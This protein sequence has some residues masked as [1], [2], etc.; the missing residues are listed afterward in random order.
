MESVQLTNFQRHRKLK[1][2]FG[3]TVNVL[4]GANDRGKTA[5]IRALYLAA[6]N[7]PRGVRFVRRGA[8]TAVVSLRADGRKVKRLRGKK[9]NAYYLDGKEF[10]AFGVNGVPPQVERLLNLSPA[11]FQ[12]Q[13]DL[14][15]WFSDTP[16]QVSK[17]LNKIVNLELIDKALARA[18]T[19]VTSATTNL[20]AARLALESATETVKGT[21]WVVAC[22]RDFE[23]VEAAGRR[24]ARISS[25]TARLGILTA[26]AEKC[27][28]ARDRAS[29]A[30]LGAEKL[31]RRAKLAAEASARAK[32]LANLLAE[33][34][35][36]EGQIRDV[37]DIS[38]LV[39]LRERGDR[40]SANRSVVEAALREYD[41]ACKDVR[42]L[43]R[44]LALAE[45]DLKLKEK[46]TPIC[47]TCGRPVKRS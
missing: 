11:S 20:E 27:R 23:R 3:P 33:A 22:A 38:K 28:A 4:V 37:P 45:R 19:K 13:H 32:K 34:E 1:V 39:R 44:N 5:V 47:P 12:H 31:L 10:K 8:A 14:H 15:Y 2:A 46:E 30:M 7:A 35:K 24:H 6:F 25:K 16:G 42:M 29:N 26:E 21:A 9:E 18:A 36:L 43:E 41:Q 17:N 40:I